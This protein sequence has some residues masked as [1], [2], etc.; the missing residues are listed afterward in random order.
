MDYVKWSTYRFASSKGF[1]PDL[2]GYLIRAELEDPQY[3]NY[4]PGTEVARRF[5]K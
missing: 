1:L 4:I 3:V 2:N 5:K